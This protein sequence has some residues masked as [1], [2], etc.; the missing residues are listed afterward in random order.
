MN[1]FEIDERMAHIVNGNVDEET[2]EITFSDKM[3]EELEELN[4]QRD[5]AIEGMCLASKNDEAFEKAVDDEIKILQEKKKHTANRRNR[6]NEFIKYLLNGQ[7]FVTPKVSTTFRTTHDVVNIA[8]ED[9][10]KTY[11]IANEM[12]DYLKTEYKIS[13]T[14]IKDAIKSGEKVPYATLV[15]N[16]S[17]TIK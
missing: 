4:I 3:L 17:M 9:A 6:R 10:A 13:K 5:Q 16:T 15:D 1:I 7:K 12:F 2:G 11:F 8:D 14:A